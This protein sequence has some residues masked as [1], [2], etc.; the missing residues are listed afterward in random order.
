[1]YLIRTP[2]R[3][4]ELSSSTHPMVFPLQDTPLEVSQSSLDVARVWM[5]PLTETR[6]ECCKL[7]CGA[8]TCSWLEAAKT[9]AWPNKNLPLSPMVQ[10]VYCV[11][12]QSTTKRGAPKADVVNNEAAT[13]PHECRPIRAH[14]FS[15]RRLGDQTASRSFQ[16]GSDVTLFRCCVCC[17]GWYTTQN[18]GYVFAHRPSALR[19]NSF[20]PQD[21]L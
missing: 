11:T 10:H 18:C 20:P 21:V 17:C 7:P 5:S 15:R 9:C 8:P 13:R 12:R 3:M 4:L 16:L 2:R 19:C 6:I 1:M 14:V